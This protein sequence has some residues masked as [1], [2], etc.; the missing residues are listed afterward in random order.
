VDTPPSLAAR[1]HLLIPWGQTPTRQKVRLCARYRSESPNV[2][3][4]LD[5]LDEQLA[6]ARVADKAALDQLQG[7]LKDLAGV[8]GAYYKELIA[9]GIPKPLTE[10]LVRTWQA[11]YWSDEIDFEI[12]EE[13]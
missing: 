8:V 1:S 13:E 5:R 11:N 6:T 2:E 10:D 4:D 12:P 3:D 7:H 9:Q